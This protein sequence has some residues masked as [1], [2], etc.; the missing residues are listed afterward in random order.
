MF[1]R[2]HMEKVKASGKPVVPTVEGAVAA[3][4]WRNLSPAEKKVFMDKLP[5]NGV[6]HVVVSSTNRLLMSILGMFRSIK[7]N[8][9][10]ALRS[11]K[12]RRRNVFSR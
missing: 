9:R 1:F 4:L 7:T 8:T 11:S 2:E 12:R 5:G 10:A 3:D 6:Y